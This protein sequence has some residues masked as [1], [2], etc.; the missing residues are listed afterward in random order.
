MGAVRRSVVEDEVRAWLGTVAAE[1]DAL[2]AGTVVASDQASPADSGATRKRLGTEATKLQ[3]AIDA[4]FEA[5]SLGDV[6]RDTYLRTRDRLTARREAVGRQLDE[7]AAGETRSEGPKP[8]G[9]VV[10]ALLDEWET[11]AVPVV[12]DLLASMVSR[13]LLV[14]GVDGQRVRV[15]PVWNA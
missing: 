11:L 5:Y 10:L 6:D 7:L 2:S 14:E 12:R 13:V 15:I 1:I 3:A 9:E 8:F 4:A